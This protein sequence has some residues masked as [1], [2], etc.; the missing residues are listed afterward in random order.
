MAST[1]SRRCHFS[2]RPPV[3]VRQAGRGSSGSISA[4]PRPWC[5]T[6]SG[7]GGMSEASGGLGFGLGQ[8]YLV[9]WASVARTPV[10]WADASCAHSSS[11]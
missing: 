11:G 9:S 1:I 8:A 3:L 6:D 4:I 2:G 7:V 10:S 5:R